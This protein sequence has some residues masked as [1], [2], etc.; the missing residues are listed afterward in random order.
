TGQLIGTPHYMSPE[1]AMGRTDVDAR[2]DIYSLGVLAFEM[3]SGNRPFDSD[4]MLD[5]LA[6]RLT[7][8][9]RP[10]G[11]VT[12]NVPSDIASAV[13][14]CLQRDRAKRWPEVRVL[15][16]ALLPFDEE[17]EES[18]PARMLRSCL[19]MGLLTVAVFAYATTYSILNPRFQ[20]P[21]RGI[22]ILIGGGF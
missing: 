7:R 12:S 16:E 2:S 17:V 15:R 13:D 5:A 19:I 22:G 14:R 18:L 4:S 8:D 21:L 9:A 3:I 6:Q 20:M 1:Q 11:S 10:I